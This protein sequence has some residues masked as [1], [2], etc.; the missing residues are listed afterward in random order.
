MTYVTVE[1]EQIP[2]LKFR[3]TDVLTNLHERKQRMHHVSRATVLGNGYHGKVE[4]FF[5][6]ADGEPKRVVTTIWDCDQEH[7]ILKSGACIP[8]RAVTGIEFY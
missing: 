3:N 8:L 4:I 2:A 1:K 6:T 7:L 5:E